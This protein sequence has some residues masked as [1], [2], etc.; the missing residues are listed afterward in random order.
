MVE[1]GD[2]RPIDCA[3]GKAFIWASEKGI[4]VQ[5]H[6]CRRRVLVPAGRGSLVRRGRSRLLRPARA[7]RRG[8]HRRGRRG[9]RARRHVVRARRQSLAARADGGPRPLVQRRS[10]GVHRVV[11]AR[12][13][14]NVGA[15]LARERG[16]TAVDRRGAACARRRSLVDEELSRD[17]PRGSTCRDRAGDRRS[18]GSSTRRPRD[19]AS[20]SS[21]A[22]RDKTIPLSCPRGRLFDQTYQLRCGEFGSFRAD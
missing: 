18:D 10:R 16:R 3:C 11:S 2:I 19:R 21:S 5:C 9:R 6:S 4:E 15:R 13:C 8:L 7:R 12:L 20:M 1:S 17:A 22:R 14:D